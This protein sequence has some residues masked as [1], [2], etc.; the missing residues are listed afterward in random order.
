VDTIPHGL[1]PFATEDAK[2]DHERVQKVAKVPPQLPTVEVFRDVV[3]TEQLHAHYGEDK[4]DDCQDE[5]EIAQCAH[6]ASD[7]TD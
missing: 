2:N 5:A 3:G 6:R 1:D 4:D 7:Y